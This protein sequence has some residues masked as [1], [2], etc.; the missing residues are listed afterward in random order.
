[1][2]TD[3]NTQLATL[4]VGLGVGAALMYYFDPARGRRRRALARDK[5]TSALGSAQEELRDRAA[6][7]AN[8][9]RGAA[10]EM[11]HAGDDHPANDTL[12]ARVR[13]ELGHRVEHAKAIEVVADHGTV[14]LRGPV[15]RDELDAAL[16]TTR[17]V[18]GVEQ[19][20]N[21]LDV[22]DTPDGISSLQGG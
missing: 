15:L 5:A 13:A 3:R 21:E 14:T 22:H 20:R 12:V 2:G 11:R 17:G 6:D 4:L 7:V 1:M 8:R 18:R 19:V 9:A 10:A 16:S